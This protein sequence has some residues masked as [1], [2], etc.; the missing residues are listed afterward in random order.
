MRV[1]ILRRWYKMDALVLS[2]SPRVRGNR[3][4]GQG[5]TRSRGS[6]PARAGE[7]L[8][9]N[10]PLLV[11]RVYPRACGGTREIRACEG[12]GQGLSPRVRGNQRAADPLE[13]R[14]GSIPA[15]AGEPRSSPF[16][17]WCSGVYPRACGGTWGS[18]P[19]RAGE[20]PTHQPNRAGRRVYPRACG[21]TRR[22]ADGLSPRVRG[23]HHRLKAEDRLVG[24]I[25]ARAGEP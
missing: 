10:V 24:S 7:P 18:I 13:F 19:A 11:P 3:S 6:I 25:P 4:A 9:L 12:R 23:N 22:M 8:V 16:T 2:L 21:G 1:R 20:P 15:R 5:Q 17:S 14:H